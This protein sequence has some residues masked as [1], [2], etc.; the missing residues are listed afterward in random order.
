MNLNPNNQH[1]NNDDCEQFEPMVS[2]MIDGELS[3]EEQTLLGDHLDDCES[4]QQLVHVF[5]GVNVAV[6]SLSTASCFELRTTRTETFVVTRQKQSLKNWLSVW[7]LVPLA[8][9]AALLIGLFLVTAQPAQKATAEQPS[10]EQ[11]VKPLADLNRINHQQQRDQ[12]MMLRTLE[13]DLRTLKLELQQLD[14]TGSEDRDRF[15]KQIEAM[16]KRVQH[17]E[18][19]DV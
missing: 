12:D 8:G 15:E 10:L 19:D 4:C 2:A 11:F 16:L 5:D 13:M 9:V 7:R 14:N 18:S 17:F 6:D 3:P 1:P